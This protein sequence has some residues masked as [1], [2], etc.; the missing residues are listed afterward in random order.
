MESAERINETNNL[1][2]VPRVPAVPAWLARLNYGTAPASEFDETDIVEADP[3]V[4]MPVN[5]D[6]PDYWDRISDEDY[7]YLTAPRKAR[8]PCFFCGGR[9]VHSQLCIE[10]RRAWI[11]MP[12]GKYKD[13]TVGNVPCDYLRW[14]LVNVNSIGPDVRAEMERV[15]RESTLGPEIAIED[16]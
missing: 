7:E 13:V 14:F 5:D 1:E 2:R 10:Q 8:A 9:N 3:V 11:V 4:E 6:W 12:C 16:T 15:M